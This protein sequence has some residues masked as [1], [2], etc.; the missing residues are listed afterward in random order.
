[1]TTTTLTQITKSWSRATSMP[2]VIDYKLN[3]TTGT[4]RYRFSMSLIISQQLKLPYAI[5]LPALLL[6]EIY[7]HHLELLEP[8]PGLWH[9]WYIC[10]IQRIKYMTCA[11][12]RQPPLQAMPRPDPTLGCEHIYSQRSDLPQA[13]RNCLNNYCKLKSAVSLICEFVFCKIFKGCPP[14]PDSPT[15]F[16]VYGGEYL[17]DFYCFWYRIKYLNHISV[18]FPC[19]FCF[20]Y[21][22]KILYFLWVPTSRPLTPPL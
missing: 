10:C 9:T 19:L 16:I 18:L 15:P 21:S 4:R 17:D 7:Q 1:L 3:T 11:M 14:P 2:A 20:F 12:S 22:R 6:W 8:L 13:I 5:V